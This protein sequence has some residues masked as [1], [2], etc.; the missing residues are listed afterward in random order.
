MWKTWDL[1]M[2]LAEKGSGLAAS[3]CIYFGSPHHHRWRTTWWQFSNREFYPGLVDKFRL[4][5]CVPVV[6]S[7]ALPFV[8]FSSLILIVTEILVLSE[9]RRSII[10]QRL[11]DGRFFHDEFASYAP[12]VVCRQSR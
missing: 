11:L 6:C 2:Y 7:Y 1:W 10:T 5:P 12:F 4:E 3:L 9:E 8:A